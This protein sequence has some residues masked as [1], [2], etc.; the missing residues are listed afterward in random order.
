MERAFSPDD[1]SAMVTWGVAPGWDGGAPLARSESPPR[2]RA[3]ARAMA[4]AWPERGPAAPP[5]CLIN[6]RPGPPP[7]PGFGEDGHIGNDA[8]GR[9]EGIGFRAHWEGQRPISSQPGAT[10]QVSCAIQNR[11]LKALPMDQSQGWRWHEGIGFRAHR[12][13]Q[14]PI[15]SQRGATPQVLCPLQHQGLKAR[16]IDQSQ[17]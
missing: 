16:P 13:G 9:H 5:R 7:R 10:P 14:R 2:M 1:F 17:T 4:R 3:M 12:E 11:G 6:A 15:S 8:G